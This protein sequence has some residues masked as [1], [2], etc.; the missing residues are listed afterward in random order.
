MLSAFWGDLSAPGEMN[1]VI[2]LITDW[3]SNY[4]VPRDNQIGERE[5]D[6]GKDERNKEYNLAPVL[7][8]DRLDVET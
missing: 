7:K 8:M 4:R 5:M 3:C 1:S 2:K 6:E